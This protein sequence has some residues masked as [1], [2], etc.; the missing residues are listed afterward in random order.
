MRLPIALLLL[1]APACTT[2]A[3]P[4][5]DGWAA[6]GEATRAGGGVTVTPVAIVEDSRCPAGVQ[7]VWAGRL[8]VRTRVDGDG[9]RL[10]DLELGEEIRVD[11][12]LLELDRAEPAPIEG[13]EI[14]AG[15]YRLHF[16]YAPMI[17]ER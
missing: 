9:S 4:R 5:A 15:D 12:G 11:D 1:A 14:A 6:I 2:V 8:V 3:E 13:V 10:A 7:C 16:R 17:M